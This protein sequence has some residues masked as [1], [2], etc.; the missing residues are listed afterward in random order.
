MAQ[1]HPR[2]PGRHQRRKRYAYPNPT[3][4][5]NKIKQSDQQGNKPPWTLPA[6]AAYATYDGKRAQKYFGHEF[7]VPA[8]FPILSLLV[9]YIPTIER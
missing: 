9:Y 4:P 3:I 5:E 2:L 1:I 6:K 7:E 8:F